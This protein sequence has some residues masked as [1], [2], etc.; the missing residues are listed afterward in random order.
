MEVPSQEEIV[1]EMLLR[2]PVLTKLV[3]NFILQQVSQFQHFLHTIERKHQLE[4][5]REVAAV[6]LVTNQL[7][8]EVLST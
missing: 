8:G 2:L 5:H 3:A 7:F 1:Q 4:T 6:Q